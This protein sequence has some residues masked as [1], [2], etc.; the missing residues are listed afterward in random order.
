MYPLLDM[1]KGVMDDGSGRVIR[2]MGFKYPAGGKTGTT[3]QFRDAWFTGFTPGLTTSVWVGYDDNESMFRPSGKGITGAHAAAPIWS[4]IMQ[5][6]LEK[7]DQ[8]D[9]PIP[10]EI[11]FENANSS[12]GFYEKKGSPN[13]ISVALNKDNSLP[14]HSKTVPISEL[15]DTRKAAPLKVKHS[16][17]AVIDSEPVEI[18]ISE[19]VS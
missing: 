17:R 7:N 19:T 3:N 16:A 8:R 2:R 12:D 14:R 10:L 4:L 5:E 1:M 6:A 18:R 13:T 9:F 15:I 11:R